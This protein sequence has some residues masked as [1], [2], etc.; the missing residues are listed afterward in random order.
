MPNGHEFEHR[1]GTRL[2]SRYPHSRLSNV[3]LFRP[4]LRESQRYGF[5]ID[6]LVHVRDGLIDR[7]FIIECKAL[8]IRIEGNRWL[9]YRDDGPHDVKEQ[10]WNQ[11]VSLMRHLA[12]STTGRQMR[13]EACVVAP[14][15][16][17]VRSEPAPDS[18]VTFHL[19]SEDRFFEWLHTQ[20][21]LIQRVEQ[22][23][24]LAELRLGVSVNEL[25]RPD[26]ANAIAFVLSCRRALD[27]ELF[28]RFPSVG[29][30]TCCDQWNRRYGEERDARL[31]SFRLVVRLLCRG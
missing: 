12:D 17:E 27:H 29:G 13:I 19:F 3:L 6:H 5:E 1:I 7:L 10:L 30:M 23:T 4:D 11:T 14:Q 21:T 2:D 8:D 22:S 18:R 28:R 9:V 20:R 16:G 15:A 31:R 25:G 26:I 24:I